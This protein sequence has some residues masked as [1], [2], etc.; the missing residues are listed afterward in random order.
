MAANT[1]DIGS[2]NSYP[3][4]SLSNLY[5]RQFVFDE[6]KCA[7][8]EGVLQSFKFDK[9]HLQVE[10][11]SLA[12]MQAKNKGKDRNNQWKIKN[13][14][15]WQLEFYK[16]REE[17]YQRLLDRLYLTVAIQCEDFRQAILDTGDLILTHQIG[18]VSESETILTQNEFCSRLMKIRNLLRKGTDLQ[19]VKKL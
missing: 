13:G 10:V 7:S 2:K 17:D 3:S 14:V 9:P 6:V 5:P 4:K 12:G 16:R 11:C 1:L 8:I 15:W 19:T 18:R